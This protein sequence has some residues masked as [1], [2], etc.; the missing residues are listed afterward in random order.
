[1]HP[2]LLSMKQRP[3]RARLF[4]AAIAPVLLAAVSACD[5]GSGPSSTGSIF[6]QTVTMGAVPDPD[7][8]Q[9]TIDGV[10]RA[11]MPSTGTATVTDVP[12]GQR[13]VRLV[14]VAEQ[15][16]VGG[17]NP[18]TAD[19]FDGDTATVDFTITCGT[20]V[21][22]LRVHVDTTGEDLDQDGYSIRA[23]E[24]TSSGRCTRWGGQVSDGSFLHRLDLPPAY[25][26][27]P[28][29][30]RSVRTHRA[31]VSGVNGF[32]RNELRGC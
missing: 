9:I 31:R 13:S 27:V 23:S 4:V 11:T 30:S 12:V 1:M 17:D 15:C 2:A 10:Q 16:T 22:S 19:V 24:T 20:P 32:M 14:G 6:V 18:R 21:G 28:F 7:G 8:Y 29:V 25:R 3:Y 5:G 26:S